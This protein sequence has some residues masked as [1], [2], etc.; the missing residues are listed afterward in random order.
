[1]N[2]RSFL[3]VTLLSVAVPA[4]AQSPMGASEFEAFTRDR[5]LF[6]YSEGLAYGV[7]RYRDDRR[8]TWSFLD[9]ECK[10]GHWYQQ[11]RFICFVY[12]QEPDPQCWTFYDDGDKLRALFEDT[13]GSTELYQA[14]EA[15][16]PMLCVGPDIGV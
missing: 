6:F 7:E 5:T 10:E 9:G 8:V 3:A 2:L 12:D 13:P 15:D 16:E 1:M 14:G 4:S 11:G